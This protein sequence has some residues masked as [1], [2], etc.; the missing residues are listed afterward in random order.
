MLS[1]GWWLRRSNS[2]YGLVLQGGGLGVLYLAIFATA[3]F[4]G[5]VPIHI[6]LL[7]MIG[8]VAL[9]CLLAINQNARSLAV[10][11]IVGGFLAP[12]L[13]S[14]GDGGHVVLFS[15]YLLL[16]TGILAIS[17]FKSWPEL[18]LLGFVFTFVIATYWE[19]SGYR[20]EHFPT[21]ESF[22]LLFFV[23]YVLISIFFAHRAPV[24]LTGYID[25]PLVFGLPLVVSSLQYFLVK[26]FPFGMAF[27]AFGLGLF[28]LLV[29]MLLMRKK[30]TLHAPYM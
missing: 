13:V 5:F 29:A 10:L 3:R 20:P 19:S 6:A 18:N 9:S 23:F 7:F 11:A 17:W 24:K 2:A 14:R 1:L 25:R 4:Y 22:L 15:Y 12:V 21:T 26:D 30:D 8:L 28:Y 27:S 16:N